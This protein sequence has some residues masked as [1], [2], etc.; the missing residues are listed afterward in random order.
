MA[1]V[2][3]IEG[4][5][6]FLGLSVPPPTPSWGNMI[7]ESRGPTTSPVQTNPYIMM[8]PA[9]A[10][11]LFL[12]A[13]NL[14]GDRLRQRFD[15]D[16]G[17]VKLMT[18]LEARA[19]DREP[20]PLLEV[21]DL[22]TVLPTG[23]G[24]APGGRRGLAHGR[25]RARRSASSASRDRA[26]PCSRARSWGC[27]RARRRASSGTVRFDGHELIG[28]LAEDA[29]VA[30]GRRDHHDLPG[31]DDRRSTRCIG[32]ARQITESLRLHLE[33][34]TGAE[35]KATGGRAP[36]PV[37]IPSPEERVRRYPFQLSGGMRQRVMIAIALACAPRLLLAD[38]PTTGLDVTV[39][40]QILDLLA[41]LQRSATWR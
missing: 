7:S 16:R 19:D 2:I 5:L 25:P 34:G 3:V 33:H 21:E 29:P 4:S 41:E 14:I 9:L 36:R 39:Q 15:I 27:S 26:R 11:F 35:A 6:A 31:P 40:A 1:T 20:A 37:G 12:L 30:L 17:A 32:S 28:G 22:H 24:P 8:W 23:R 10:M 38:E 13:I 18:S